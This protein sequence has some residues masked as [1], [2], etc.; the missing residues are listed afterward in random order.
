MP[1]GH[2]WIVSELC[3]QRMVVGGKQLSAVLLAAEMLQDC[4]CDRIP[5]PQKCLGQETKI[6]TQGAIWLQ[7]SSSSLKLICRKR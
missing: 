4:M 1:Q 7:L 2:A 5:A 3:S 6:T